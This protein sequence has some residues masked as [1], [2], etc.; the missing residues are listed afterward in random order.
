M[1]V[2]EAKQVQHFVSAA[3]KNHKRKRYALG[4][5]KKAIAREPGTLDTIYEVIYVDVVDRAKPVSGRTK[6]DFPIKTTNKITVDSIIYPAVDDSTATNVGYN[7]LPN[8]R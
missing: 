1:Q 3:A 7:Q 2:F 5:V 4:E 8:I 6:S